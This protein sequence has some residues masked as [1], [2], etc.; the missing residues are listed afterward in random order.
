MKEDPNYSDYTFKFAVKNKDLLSNKDM[1]NYDNKLSFY[2][3]LLTSKTIYFN[4]WVS[5]P[6]RK[7]Q[8]WIQLWHGYP[9]KKIFKDINTFYLTNDI[10]EINYKNSNVKKWDMVHSLD[11][12]NTYIF[13]K[14][15][16]NATIIEVPYEKIEWLKT[17]NKNKTF[18]NKILEDLNLD[19]NIKYCLYAPTYRPYPIHIDL[20]EVKKLV[21]RGQK[22]CIHSHRMLN[23][24][25]HNSDDVLFIDE[26]EDVQPLS[27][28]CESLITD[29]SSLRFEFEQLNREVVLYQPDLELYKQIQGIY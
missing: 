15:F 22:L 13:K 27:L 25:Y 6:K 17:Y 21:P 24:C 20:N 16:S 8:K 10:D 29:Y 23:V 14:L 2:Y 9:Y 26:L 18:K 4:S 11:R 5:F 3:H 28:I 19:E 1:I 12:R 7:G